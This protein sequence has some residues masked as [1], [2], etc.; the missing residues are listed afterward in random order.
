MLRLV[1]R[2]W[3]LS[4]VV[5]HVF[6]VDGVVNKLGLVVRIKEI[7]QLGALPHGIGSK[8]VVIFIVFPVDIPN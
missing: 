2:Q 8:N 1:C 6:V 3:I 4:D 5:D 7:E